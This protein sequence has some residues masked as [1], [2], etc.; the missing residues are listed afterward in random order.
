M[1][2]RKRRLFFTCVC[3]SLCVHALTLYLFQAHALWFSP[4]P[5]VQNPS[6]P[7]EMADRRQI[8]KEVFQNLAHPMP[9]IA[10]AP[11]KMEAPLEF[12]QNLSLLEIRAP[13]AAH[14]PFLLPFTPSE[15]F[16]SNNTLPSRLSPPP[17]SLHLFSVDASLAAFSFPEPEA[18]EPLLSPARQPESATLAKG[19]L[20]SIPLPETTLIAYQ[21]KGFI[22]TPLLS[23][24][25]V[26]KKAALAIPP[27]PL[28]SFPTLGELD[29]YSY[30]DSFDLDIVCCP[31]DD[32]KSG[33]LFAATL[34][35]HQDLRLPKI[36]QHYSFLIDRANSIQRERLLA[37]KSAVLRAVD[38][39]DTDDT[40]NIIVFDSKVEKA[41]AQNR[42]L[43]G[44]SLAEARAFLDKIQLGS[45]FAPADLYN[46]LF[47]T[48]PYP[49]KENE[50]YTAILMTD[51]EAL[52]KKTGVRSIL[53][54]WTMQNS[55]KTS[56]YTLGM[57]SDSNLSGLDAASA[58]NRGHLYSSPTKR[59]IKRKLLKMMKTIR[60]PIAKNLSARAISTS[61]ASIELFPSGSH[62][63]HLYLNQPIVILG[64]SETLDDFILFVQGRSKECWFNVKKRVSFLNAKKGGGSLRK[65]WA[66]QQ[67]Y[68]CYENYTRDDNPEHL[69]EARRLLTPFDIQTAFE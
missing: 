54:T 39:L 62:I 24:A 20:S 68:R 37:T 66:M 41:F 51:G 8:L 57:G 56:L 40:F 22:Q 32:G 27:P 55:G 4:P 11:Q 16:A 46:P 48:L 34:I 29:T 21:D 44:D 10:I 67:A 49:A 65:G 13:E 2:G 9:T 6:I 59:G 25:Q 50:V 26:R 43:S 18:A 31:R 45:F 33:T 14:Q 35:P 58:L 23:E 5:P 52:S 12:R 64:S 15:L 69:A 17:S 61:G 7:H 3:F 36:R 28:P 47:L 60:A 63:P 1:M 30:S 42:P 38:E 53:N 19:E